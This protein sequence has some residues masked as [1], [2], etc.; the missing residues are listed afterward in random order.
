ME[1]WMDRSHPIHLAETIPPTILPYLR[2]CPVHPRRASHLAPHRQ[3]PPQDSR[4]CSATALS[5]A[6]S[7]A[8]EAR[9]RPS[10][11]CDQTKVPRWTLAIPYCAASLPSHARSLS[12]LWESQLDRARA[13]PWLFSLQPCRPVWPSWHRPIS[14]IG[15]DYNTTTNRCRCSILRCL[16]CRG[17]LRFSG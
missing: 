13:N 7:C 1:C 11:K 4:S 17:W 12:C 14:T 3:Y 16:G 2:G 5:L 6:Q 10:M 8:W 15:P 9:A